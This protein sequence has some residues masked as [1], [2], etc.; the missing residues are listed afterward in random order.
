MQAGL[1]P[2]KASDGGQY[3]FTSTP[4]SPL[5]IK[6]H[7]LWGNL[8]RVD[9]RL[10]TENKKPYVDFFDKNQDFVVSARHMPK[11]GFLYFH[12]LYAMA[13]FLGDVGKWIRGVKDNDDVDEVLAKKIKT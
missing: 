13:P 2:P 6:I 10:N 4:Y 1:C 12:L 8:T 7:F 5:N 3:P 9:V 11:Y